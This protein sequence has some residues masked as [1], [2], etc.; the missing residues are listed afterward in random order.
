[1]SSFNESCIPYVITDDINLL[2]NKLLS[3]PFI[4][5]LNNKFITSIGPH[6]QML[7]S[8]IFDTVDVIE[9]KNI[10]DF[11]YRSTKNIDL[12]IVSLTNIIG[13]E[14]CDAELLISRCEVLEFVDGEPRYKHAGLHSRYVGGK[15]LD[16]QMLN[17]SSQFRNQEIVLIDDVIYSGNTMASII[18]R[19]RESGVKVQSVFTNVILEKAYNRLVDFDVKIIYDVIYS[20][21]IDIVCL[22]DFI[23]GLPGGGRNVLLN[24]S[25][26]THAPYIFPFGDLNNWANIPNAKTVEFSAQMLEIARQFWDMIDKENN[27]LCSILMLEKPPV[28]W[29]QTTNLIVEGLSIIIEQ[30]L[31][32]EFLSSSLKGELYVSAA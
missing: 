27:I 10:Y 29:P 20:H 28:I 16:Q 30:K 26:L 18:S 6:I 5:I 11:L 23:F 8:S 7:L 24:H 25:I 12:P 2:A 19:L 14:L 4:K 13:S 17:L 1:M 21:V 31:Y 15:N 9:S 3:N 22:R 32:E